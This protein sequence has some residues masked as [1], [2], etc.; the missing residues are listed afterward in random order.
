[1]FSKD[2]Q[3]KKPSTQKLFD[4]AHNATVMYYS[5]GGIESLKFVAKVAIATWKTLHK[6]HL[7]KGSIFWMQLASKGSCRFSRIAEDVA[8]EQVHHWLEAS[9]HM[10]TKTH[11][12]S[13]KERAQSGPMCSTEENRNYIIERLW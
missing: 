9:K 11:D 10:Y 12:R 1:V 5:Q 8:R 6:D 2:K 13:T 7:D 3:E 4:L